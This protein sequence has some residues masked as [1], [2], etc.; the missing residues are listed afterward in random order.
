MC[1]L[2][3]YELKDFP[4]W[5]NSRRQICRDNFCFCCSIVTYR[6]VRNGLL[7]SLSSHM[8]TSASKAVVS[9][10][11]RIT[12]PKLSLFSKWI[13]SSCQVQEHYSLLP[14]TRALQIADIR[15]ANGRKVCV[16]SW[17]KLTPPSPTHKDLE[18]PSKRVLL[19]SPIWDAFRDLEC[20]NLEG[21]G[22]CY[23]A[24]LQPSLSCAH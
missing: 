12:F 3:L 11:S 20:L 1:S 14:S 7:P 4:V 17:D 6:S 24:N 21:A 5:A 9:F 2:P 8:V 10:P 18:M 19:I 16:C 22:N 15:N 13:W 23:A